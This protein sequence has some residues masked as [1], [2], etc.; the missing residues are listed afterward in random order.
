MSTWR[1]TREGRHF[2][3]RYTEDPKHDYNVE[4][5]HMCLSCIKIGGVWLVPYLQ[6]V[7]ERTGENTV[8]VA[9][10]Q[11]DEQLRYYITRAGFVI[12]E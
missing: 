4:W 12:E 6:A 11:I 10:G 1:S 8:R 5:T 9:Q 2:K 7:I 3:S